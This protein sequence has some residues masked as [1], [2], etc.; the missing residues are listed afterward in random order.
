MKSDPVRAALRCKHPNA[1]LGIEE[2][3][4]VARQTRFQ[5]PAAGLPGPG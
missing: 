2:L 5:D 1:T 4:F 3:L